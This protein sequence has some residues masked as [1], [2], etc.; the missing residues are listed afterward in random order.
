MNASIFLFGEERVPSI[1]FEDALFLECKEG[2]KENIS[3]LIN[4]SE[5]ELENYLLIN[6]FLGEIKLHYYEFVKDTFDCL[7]NEEERSVL[8]ICKANYTFKCNRD[9]AD[10]FFTHRHDNF[11]SV[12]IDRTAIKSVG[13]KEVTIER[14]VRLPYFQ[15]FILNDSFDMNTYL[16]NIA[17][18]ELMF[19]FIENL[20]KK[21]TPEEIKKFNLRLK[22]KALYFIKQEALKMQGVLDQKEISEILKEKLLNYNLIFKEEDKE[23]GDKDE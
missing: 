14:I 22:E 19:S 16:K 23:M 6:Y 8:A 17:K 1:S 4:M 18:N 11:Y 20:I 21:Y 3:T 5:D 10:L 13:L 15:D 7:Y 12:G 2:L 9:V